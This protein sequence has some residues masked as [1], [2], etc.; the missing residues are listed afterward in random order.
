MICPHCKKNIEEV[1]ERLLKLLETEKT[2][3][4]LFKETG[5]SFGTIAYHL[6]SF[7]DEKLVYISRRDIKRRGCPTFYIK[8]KEN[9]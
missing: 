2:P 9:K 6:K 8:F 4:H 3:T 1:R 7:V 5:L